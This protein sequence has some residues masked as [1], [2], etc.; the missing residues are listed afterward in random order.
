MGND[1][2]CKQNRIDVLY[3]CLPFIF[4][5]EPGP[6][7]PG[8][9]FIFEQ[10]CLCGLD[11]KKISIAEKKLRFI[12]KNFNLKNVVAA[13]KNSKLPSTKVKIAVYIL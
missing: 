2:H 9:L 11:W 3:V 12:D 5:L 10:I 13:P 4:A 7:H 1:T 8:H 6:D